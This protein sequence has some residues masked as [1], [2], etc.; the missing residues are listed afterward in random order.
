MSA[1]RIDD[2]ARPRLPLPVK[3]LNAAAAPLAR[4]LFPL[5]EAGLLAA[6]RKQTC[7]EDF[8]DDG[9]RE[10]LRVLLDAL[11]R[12]ADLTALGRFLTR[13]L[14][15]QLLGTRLRAQDLVAR[16]PEILAEPI[17][18]PIVIMGLPRTG[19]THLHN[20]IS[21]DPDL[22]SLA[23]W[24]S[25]DPVPFDA[26][27]P[28]PGA[29]DPRIARCAQAL[30]L[31]HYVMPLFPLMHEMTPEAR[32]EEIQLLAVEFSTMLF[33]AS[34]QVP[35][36]RDWYAAS[37]QTPAYAM[38]KRLLQILQWRSGRARRWV[39]KSPQHL[40]SL[41]ALDAVYPDARIVQT[42]R[43]PVKVAASLASLVGLLRGMGSD[44]VD[45]AEIGADWS[46][47]LAEGL[48]RAMAVR[49]A[50]GFDASRVFD[51][52]FRDFY[53]DPLGVVH[54]IYAHFGMMLG[55]AA[56]RNMRR[57]IERHP[58]NEHGRHEYTLQ[59][60]GLELESERGR[61]EAYQKLFDIPS[62]IAV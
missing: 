17:E 5:G 43:D 25:L 51:V 24:E 57:F 56:E 62:E 22:A 35:S 15:L 16:H 55:D 21:Q 12:E 32:H 46:R 13:Q 40:W 52:H 11:E 8:G 45:P 48:R 61:F 54:R 42:H 31:V 9:F 6:A 41:D 23:Y 2:Y 28:E 37:D 20:L 53:T 29:P 18:A 33:E 34:Y 10:P 36:Y 47:R 60:A 50:P 59:G 14:L 49:E 26:D 58:Q 1:H 7:L 19:T 30:R 3:A 38:L 27:L 44:D 4:R 39:L